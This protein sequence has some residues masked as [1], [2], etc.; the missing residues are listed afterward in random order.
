MMKLNPLG[1][2]CIVLVAAIT[3]TAAH[4]IDESKFKPADIITRDVAVVGGGAAGAYTAV[5]VKDHGK[6]VV[7]IDAA[8]HLVGRPG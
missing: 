7:L 2:I 8:D 3:R 6:T 5:R 1:V 4:T